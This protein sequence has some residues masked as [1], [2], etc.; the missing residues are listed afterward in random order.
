MLRSPVFLCTKKHAEF[1]RHV[2]A[3]E[4]RIAS[5]LSARNIVDAVTAFSDYPTDL[6]K[7]VVRRIVRLKR[8][9]RDE[10]RPDYSE[11]HCVEELTIFRVKGAIDENVSIFPGHL[12]LGVQGVQ[13]SSS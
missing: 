4:G 10:A 13:E 7:S 12:F 6:V 11:Y 8:A 9:T 1:E 2:E 5:K 3:R